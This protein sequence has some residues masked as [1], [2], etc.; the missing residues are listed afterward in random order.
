MAN[1]I[2]NEERYSKLVV[3]SSVHIN[4][5]H[6]MNWTSVHGAKHCH[7][8]YGE[9]YE[10]DKNTDC[11]YMSHELYNENDEFVCASA[12]EYP[13]CWMKVVEVDADKVVLVRGD[14]ENDSRVTLT[15]EE[16]FVAASRFDGFDWVITF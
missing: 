1:E 3:G 7:C 10:Y 14:E 11:C 5:A 16:L 6:F 2:Y 9:D 12:I 15:K 4:V 8:E 13:D